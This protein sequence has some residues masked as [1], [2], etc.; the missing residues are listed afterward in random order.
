MAERG[1]SRICPW[2]RSPNDRTAG[3]D[4]VFRQRLLAL[5]SETEGIAVVG[6][7]A[8]GDEA[9]AAA[10]ELQPEVVLMDLHMPALNGVEAT[11]RIVA[12]SPHVAVLVL[13]MLEDDD[14]VFA[15]MGPGPAAIC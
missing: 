1:F 4:P 5:L 12:D 14:S 11:R 13:T 10:A 7:A 2:T 6:E 8:T 15:A 9:V 3:P